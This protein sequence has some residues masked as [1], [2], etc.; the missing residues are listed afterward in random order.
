MALT[1]TIVLSLSAVM[2]ALMRSRGRTWGQ[3]SSRRFGRGGLLQLLKPVLQFCNRILETPPKEVLA[4][5]PQSSASGRGHYIPIVRSV[6]SV[7][8]DGLGSRPSLAP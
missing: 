1:L 5:F 6:A 7:L 2:Y 8:K 3:R 4:A